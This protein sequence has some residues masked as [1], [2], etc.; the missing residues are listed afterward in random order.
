[1]PI[2]INPAKVRELV[3][4]L[5]AFQ[6]GQS[7]GDDGVA[8]LRSLLEILHDL[9]R[10]V[11]PDVVKGSIIVFGSVDITSVIKDDWPSLRDIAYAAQECPLQNEADSL[12][13]E[14]CSDRSLRYARNAELDLKL[15]SEEAIVYV[16]R[17]RQDAFV[18]RGETC[19]IPNPYAGYA[20]IFSVPT[21]SELR[22]ALEDYKRRIVR[23]CN[24]E[25]LSHSWQGGGVGPRLFFVHGP[26]EAMRKSLAQFLNAV[27][28]ETEVAQEQNV[29]ETHPVDIKITW[30]LCNRIA[31][32]EVK[33]L[34]KSVAPDGHRTADHGPARAN[35]G[36]RQLAE[37]IDEAYQRTPLHLRRG[38]LVVIDGRRR[39]LYDGRISID[40]E[41]GLWYQDQEITYEPAYHRDRTDFE[42]PIRMFAEPRWSI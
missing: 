36:A 1:M 6:I 8:A 2:E 40:R 7:Y 39:N 32:I 19:E 24:C 23:T 15:L 26:E 9:Y 18:I 37:Y 10:H 25:I 30:M 33:W 22:D 5:Y 21:F 4:H 16:Y 42:E 17:N 38:Y 3:D 14:V 35:T 28:R 11:D 41:N 13:V 27:L 31:L 34:G 29:D 20:S 12:S